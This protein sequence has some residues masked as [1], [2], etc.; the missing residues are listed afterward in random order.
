MKKIISILI[1][2]LLIM[3]SLSALA[4]SYD[5][6]RCIIYVATTGDDANNGSIDKP[7]KTLIGAR[8]KIRALRSQGVAPEKGFVVYVRGGNY[9]LNESFV[10]TEEDSGT[11]AAPV[12][13]RSYP[14]E[15]ATFVGGVKLTQKDFTKVTDTA[16]TDRI[17][18][19][20][21]RSKIY[22]YDLKKAGITDV[23]PTYLRG[24]YSYRAITEEGALGYRDDIER[25]K[26]PGIEMLVDG[27]A[28]H[29][30]QY[31]NGDDTIKIEQLLDEGF[32]W[33]NNLSSNEG[34]GTPF[35]IKVG[36]KRLAKWTHLDPQ[37]IIMYGKWYFDWA[38]QSIPMGSF[39]AA[40]G[41]ITSSSSSTHGLLAGRG[42]IV[43][44]LLEELDEQGEY[45]IDRATSILYCYEPKNFAKAEIILTI[46]DAP[47]IDIQKASH[48]QFKH[49][50]ITGSRTTM[51]NITEGS[52]FVEFSNCELSFSNSTTMVI[53]GKNCG[54]RDSYIHDINTGIDLYGGHVSE[55]AP[56]NCY[57]TN[58]EIEN[59][60]RTARTYAPAINIGG[61]KNEMTH[62]K[63]HNAPHQGV[64]F[65]GNDYLIAY[66]EIYDV[67]KEADDMAAI[68]GGISW[69]QRGGQ[70]KYNYIHDVYTS[71]TMYSYAIYIDD[72]GSENTVMGNVI[73]DNKNVSLINGGRDNYFVN[74]IFVNNKMGYH[75]SN[76][77]HT[78]PSRHWAD[79][80][81]KP[82]VNSPAF[83]NHYPNFAKLFTETGEPIGNSYVLPEDNLYKNNVVVNT[84]TPKYIDGAQKYLDETGNFNTNKDP[85][86]YD[87][88]N[89]NYML[90]ED[91]IV[92]EELPDFEPLP[93]T[94]MGKLDD[95]ADV[96]VQDVICLAVD[97]PNSLVKGKSTPID[98]DNA[99][100][101]PIIMNSRT[102]VP[103]RFIS[104]KLGLNVDY[105]SETG[106][107][108]I[109][110][111]DNTLSLF[112]DNPEVK[113]NGESY[114][115]ENAAVVKDGRTLVPLREIS[116]L[117]GKQVY[118]HDIGFIVISDDE[119][120]FDPTD[121]TEETMIHYLYNKMDIY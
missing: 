79:Q 20:A 46:L 96:R 73:A 59:I 112:A 45:Y 57:V 38:D 118:W 106:E 121:S 101:T 78:D 3:S 108:T 22:M 82:Y 66:N 109:A 43:Y 1:A 74:N 18:D 50:N 113:K 98:A 117:F 35:V 42:F 107:I 67:V 10:L 92:F 56:G 40:S 52:E 72:L 37:S 95:L 77:E 17:I 97:S 84:P 48:I 9:T 81:S 100:V 16:I 103:L 94:R 115:M 90:K 116:N 41:V 14:G 21:A 60:G 6:G 23:G 55:L 70:I 120:I 13:Y 54:I 33:Y 34:W 110:G 102:F 25:P 8:D 114:T 64:G 105:N 111:G 51:V 47:L 53:R 99:A 27:A 68:Y 91:S 58:C 44:D 76:R 4:N 12:V 69:N 5:N 36:D 119:A 2:A 65:G 39:D 32:N 49:L 87:M 63:I 88:E 93:F 15:T 104:E 7:L 30:A 61:Y 89:K 11:E 75:I 71:S 31:P 80:N 29:L 24:T 85:G 62:N 83:R 28:Y 19:G 86:F 26:A